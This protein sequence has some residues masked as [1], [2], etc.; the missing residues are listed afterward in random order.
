ML[1]ARK[2]GDR[3]VVGLTL[4]DSL[5]DMTDKDLSL[6]ENIPFWK[7]KGVKD[8]YVFAEDLTF[9]TDLLRF[10]DYIFKNITDGNSV[11]TNVI[12][13]MKEVLNKYSQIVNGKEWDSQLL[14]IK[15]NK[16]FTIDNYF[17]VTEV[18][19]FV[20]V[21]Y[22][23]YLLGGLEE[24]RDKTI[25]ESILFAV[26][27]LNRMRSRNLFPLTLFDSKTKKIRVVFK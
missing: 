17:T 5:I 1:I 24:S 15:D 14:I 18:D 7:V 26:R 13:K 25:E 9:A 8:C 22:W 16:M 11:I 2:D 3:I 19:E 12:P 4:A 27:N 10:N 23:G 6:V 20:G 21:G